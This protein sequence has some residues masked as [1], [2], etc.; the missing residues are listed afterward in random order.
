MATEEFKEFLDRDRAT[1]E[2][3]AL[4][5]ATCPLL[6]ELVNHASNAFTRV[7]RAADAG[8][9]GGEN[10]DL[11]IYVLY[12]QI[13]EQV[14]AVEVLLQRAASARP[15]RYCV[16]HSRHL[17]PWTTSWPIRASTS[18]V[19]SVGPTHTFARRC[20]A[21]ICSIQKLSL[22]PPSRQLP[23]GPTARQTCPG[24]TRQRR[25]RI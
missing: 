8:R 22:V 12:D 17:C 16:R 3:Q 14:D 7:L 5:E 11:A 25:S 13:I 19:R 15:R 18:N 9:R 21:T 6:R 1:V 23:R 2:A 10:E 20:V 24:S 4:I